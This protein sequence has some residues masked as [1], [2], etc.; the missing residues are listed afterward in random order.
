MNF[1]FTNMSDVFNVTIGS[2]IEC[3]CI[4][5]LCEIQDE[6]IV[7]SSLFMKMMLFWNCF[8]IGFMSMM[9]FMTKNDV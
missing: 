8:T 6:Y 4:N 1:T 3:E 5:T 2:D 7:E 9:Y